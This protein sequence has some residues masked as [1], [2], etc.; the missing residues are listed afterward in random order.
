MYS[1]VVINL[2]QMLGAGEEALVPWLWRENARNNYNAWTRIKHISELYIR[3]FLQIYS[4]VEVQK[5]SLSSP[6]S[7]WFIPLRCTQSSLP[8]QLSGW[9]GAHGRN[10][11]NPDKG[12]INWHAAS[13]SIHQKWRPEYNV[14]TEL[15]WC[16]SVI[17]YWSRF[18]S[19]YK[20]AFNIDVIQTS[21]GFPWHVSC[22]QDTNL[23]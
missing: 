22:T 19:V 1:G 14:S 8:C 7:W 4:L 21:P 2:G 18:I 13:L 12:T 10:S 16:F 23:L 17:T 9:L 5:S 6:A 15:W 11:W 20:L 3:P